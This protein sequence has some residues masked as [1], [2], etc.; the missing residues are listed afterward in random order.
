MS[1]RI[2]KE[3]QGNQAIVWSGFEKGIATSPHKGI[4]NMQCVNISTEEGEVMCTYSRVQQSQALVTSGVDALTKASTSILAVNSGITGTLIR[5]G[6]WI[7]VGASTIAGLT[8]NTDYYVIGQNSSPTNF[9]IQLSATFSTNSADIITGYGTGTAS[10][11]QIYEMAAAVQN[12]T[13]RYVDVNGVTQYR[14][15]VLDVNGRLWVHDTMTLTGVDT[16]YWFLPYRASITNY[17]GGLDTVARGLGLINGI[18]FIFGAN[19]IYTVSTSQ[20]GIIPNAPSPFGKTLSTPSSTNPHFAF[21]GHQGRLYY[22]DGPFIGSIF[23]NVSVDTGLTTPIT[24]IQSYGSFTSSGT[25]GTITAILNGSIPSESSIGTPSCIPVYLFAAFVGGTKPTAITVGTRYFLKYL[26]TV[27]GTFEIYAA[28]TGG[29][30]IDITTGAVGTQYFTTFWPQSGDGNL[31]MVFSPERLLLP[32][33]EIAT[34]I[35]E[36]GNTVV[37]GTQSNYLYPWNQV[38]LLPSDPLPMPESYT[39]SM[40]TVNNVLYIFAGFRGNIYITNASSVSLAMTVPDYC[41]GLIE[42]YFIWGG[43]MFLRGRVYFSIQ[44]Q[45]ASHTGNCGGVWSFTPV[46][47][48]YIDQDVGIALHLE[49]KNSYNTYNGKSTLLISAVDQQAQGPQYWSVWTSSIT[50]PKYGIDFSNTVPTQAAVIQTDVV[51][52]G[53]TLDKKTFSQLEYKLSTPLVANESVSLAYRT[54]LSSAFVSAGTVLV[55]SITDLAGY[56]PVNFEK[57]QWVQVQ[58]TLTPN[59]DTNS[60]FVRLTE[61]RLR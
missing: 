2:E 54:N 15:Y 22:T 30:A 40:V 55:E 19:G 31:T 50:N 21:A 44:D 12:A 28:Q 25:T 47:N 3:G 53:T 35:S 60:T 14:Y 26:V 4:A 39:S 20:L 58:V 61:V 18:L 24:N 52:T 36:L 37:I 11:T 23:P 32:S 6:S 43:S 34:T 27:P 45:T 42:P 1:Y 48:F 8:A 56:L 38:D 57:T 9:F 5:A 59:N 46:Q 51:P 29:A 7:H 10:F 41:T 13:E 49:N 17:S 16:P 33:N